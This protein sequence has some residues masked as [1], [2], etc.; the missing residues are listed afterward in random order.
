[1]PVLRI[2]NAVRWR[3]WL[4]RASLLHITTCRHTLVELEGRPKAWTGDPHEGVDG[5]LLGAISFL[6]TCP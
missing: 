4:Y 2:V 1:M 5:D 6:R 3:D